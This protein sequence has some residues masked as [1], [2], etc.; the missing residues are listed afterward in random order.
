MAKKAS[1]TDL[2]AKKQEKIQKKLEAQ[3]T[4]KRK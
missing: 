1:T 3:Q 2:K 4:K